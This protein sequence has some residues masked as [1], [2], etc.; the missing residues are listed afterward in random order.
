MA[1][2]PPDASRATASP[3]HATPLKARPP[4]ARNPISVPRIATST[5]VGTAPK[6]RHRYGYSGV[7][8]KE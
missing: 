6:H 2:A 5:A 3:A 1:S 7:V 4:K 8:V